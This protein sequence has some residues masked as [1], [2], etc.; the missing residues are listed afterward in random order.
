M[1]APNE[2]E[3]SNNPFIMS[4]TSPL[5]VHSFID[6]RQDYNKIAPPPK[7]FDEKFLTENFG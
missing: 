4:K 2:D 3:I 1:D 5:G 6:N 7:Y